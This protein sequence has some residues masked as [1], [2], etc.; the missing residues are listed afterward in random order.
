[1]KREQIT[2]LSAIPL[3]FAFYGETS[4][5][6]PKLD[7][8]TDPAEE[9]EGKNFFDSRWAWDSSTSPATPPS[10]VITRQL[11]N[12]LLGQISGRQFLKQCGALDTFDQN[13]CDAIGGYPQGAVLQYLDGDVLYD[14]VSMRDNNDTDYTKIG[15]DGINWRIYG[16]SVFSYVYPDYGSIGQNNILKTWNTNDLGWSFVFRGG[17]E[18]FLNRL[19]VSSIRYDETNQQW[20]LVVNYKENGNIYWTLYDSSSPDSTSITFIGGSTTVR[21]VASKNEGASNYGVLNGIV[22]GDLVIHSPCWIQAFITNP[23]AAHGMT[24][25]EC[26]IALYNESTARPSA[27][28]DLK[29]DNTNYTVYELEEI[30]TIATAILPVLPGN[31][32]SAFVSQVLPEDREIIIRKL[33]PVRTR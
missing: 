24:N 8:F 13:V 2:D 32:I 19:Y 23:T 9:A 21:V 10:R 28:E 6:S 33:T 16:S 25:Y 26:G 17:T 27:I 29:F 7:P 1:M 31:K 3:P 20:V 14:V 30:G 12:R 11:M 22:G 15:V 18:E 5:A 4:V